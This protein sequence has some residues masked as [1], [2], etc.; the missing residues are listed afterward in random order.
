MA[1]CKQ[2][3]HSIWSNSK[4]DGWGGGIARFMAGPPRMYQRT[5]TLMIYLSNC[6]T[7]PLLTSFTTKRNHR[8]LL[9]DCENKLL[10]WDITRHEAYFF[11]RTA[12]VTIV[13]F[14]CDDEWVS[15]DVLCHMNSGKGHVSVLAI[16]FVP[17]STSN[18]ISTLKIVPSF[19][20][21]ITHTSSN[22]CG[23][24]FHTDKR[25]HL[26]FIE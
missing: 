14:E 21:Q 26:R 12:N 2:R 16:S 24:T 5:K 20:W 9:W 6:W 7:S 4:N 17:T 10:P 18:L 13:S 23:M 22:V 25:T 11:H 8:W 15:I 1:D 3:C 19:V